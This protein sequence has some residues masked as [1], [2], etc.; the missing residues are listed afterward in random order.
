MHPAPADSKRSSPTNSPTSAPPTVTAPTPTT[1]TQPPAT[2]TA[3]PPPATTTTTTASADPAKCTK[4]KS[5]QNITFSKTKY[6]R[7][8]AHFLKALR[9][10]W[11]RTLGLNRRG[12]DDRRQKLLADIPTK[13]GYDRDE[14]PPA[15][16]RDH[17]YALERRRV[18]PQDVARASEKVGIPVHGVSGASNQELK[19]ILDEAAI[20]GATSVLHVVRADPNGSYLENYRR[21]QELLREAAP[22]AEKLRIPILIENVWATFLIEPL[23]MARY[24]DELNSPFVQAYFDVGNCMRWGV[25]QQWIEVLGKRI[26]SC[27]GCW[28]EGLQRT[29]G[30]RDL[31][32]PKQCRRP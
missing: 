7:I 4:A 19:A 13:R 32:S 28:D 20:Y 27:L 6:P 11:P 1:E 24:I 21:S 26:G 29:W 15:V 2:S 25:P 16:G 30:N 31:N 12:A 14:Y 9:R 18:A 22:H 8:R 23:T 17:E 5:V 3:Q 10:G